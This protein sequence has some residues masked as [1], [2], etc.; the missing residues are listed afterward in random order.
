MTMPHIACGLPPTRHVPWAIPMGLY[1]RDLV[2]VPL[3]ALFD[4]RMQRDEIPVSDRLAA[5]LAGV[6]I[7]A[8]AWGVA[9]SIKRVA[10]SGIL[11]EVMRATVK[12]SSMVFVILVAGPK[13]PASESKGNR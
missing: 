8:L 12:I 6:A 2:L 9:V 3:T 7:L 13:V 11:V 5:I 10:A 1:Y 4:L